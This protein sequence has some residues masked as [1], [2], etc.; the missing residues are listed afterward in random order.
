MILNKLWAL[1]FGRYICLFFKKISIDL[2]FC[3][4]TYG[5]TYLYFIST[6]HYLHFLF[7]MKNH[8]KLFFKSYL[9]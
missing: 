9:I 4:V 8:A 3:V 5:Y 6:K 2:S 7:Y 1:M